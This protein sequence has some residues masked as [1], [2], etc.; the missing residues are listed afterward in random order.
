MKHR[1]FLI[2]LDGATFTVLD[3]LM[4]DGVMPTLRALTEKG[5]K[6]KLRSTPHPLTPPAWISMITGRSPGNHGVFDFVRVD[7][8]DEHLHYS[9]ATA[10]DNECE[11]VWSIAGRQGCSV[12]AFNFAISYPPEPINGVLVPGFIPWRHLSRAVYPPEAYQTIKT[13]PGFDPKELSVDWESETEAIQAL[14]DEGYEEWI[15]F[16]IRREEQWFAIFDYFVE[17][18]P[19][20]LTAI[21][22]DGVDKLQHTCWRFLD[23]G[24]Q[25]TPGSWEA[26][27]RDLC[28][29]YF[30]LVDGF[31]AKIAERA[32]EEARLFFAS[33]HGFGPSDRIF[34]VNSWLAE[35]GYLAWQDSV[36]LAEEERL[37]GQGHKSH[38]MLF[39][40][41]RTRA[42]A[43]TASS[44]GIYIRSPDGRA[45]SEDDY[46]R[47]RAELTAGLL[48]IQDPVTAEP[49]LRHVWTREE[50]FPGA[51]S[52]RA[53]DLTI[54]LRDHGFISVLRSESAVKVRPRI[55]GTHKPDGVFIAAGPG[56]R[57]GESLER[58]LSIMD[59]A[60]S[61]LYS[62]G[63]P[64]PQ[65]FEGR[66]PEEI[67]DS[68]QLASAPPAIGAATRNPHEIRDDQG[69]P[70]LSGEDEK[71]I[72]ERLKALGYM[73]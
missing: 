54:M 27:I 7:R 24:F 13:I 31:I 49:L 69:G 10:T 37:S 73:E 43:L 72:F 17:H 61:L 36:P 64:I 1:T 59:V 57:Q 15:R 62:V 9:L 53:P 29:D 30:R 44:N 8:K 16:H 66:L 70:E 39:D 55:V 68:T 48:A 63:L 56:I 20:D 45:L 46:L 2:G 3:P 65:D 34:Y 51:Q 35:N 11:T 41:S 18:E 21:V 33:D 42:C 40:W 6:A 52:E 4:R 60:P 58:T 23:P 26:G 38:T 67:F 32:G 71:I 19:A 50:A 22:F 25:A 5:A 28:L 47:L 12:Q 14:P